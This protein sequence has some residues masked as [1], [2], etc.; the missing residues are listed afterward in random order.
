MSDQQN[1]SP[2]GPDKNRRRVVQTVL[3]ASPILATL[4][5]RPVQAVQ[6]LS[7]MLSGNASTCRGDT[8][9]GGM[10]PGYWLTPPG[11]TVPYADTHEMAWQLTG[12]EYG[13]VIAG[14]INTNKWEDFEGGTPYNTVFGGNDGRPLRLV[15][16]QDTGSEQFHLIA[17]LLNAIYFEAK[18]GAGV[19]EYIITIQQF[20]DLF[21]GRLEI[22]NAYS[23]LRDMIEANYHNTPGS[24]CDITI[25]G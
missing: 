5:S 9:Y 17:G 18:A 12:Y 7:N 10:S 16:G 14:V 8:R 11:R 19:T 13:T 22:P 21:Y 15:L 24:D 1:I 20:W 23:S 2:S 6:G 25:T 4:N 3:A